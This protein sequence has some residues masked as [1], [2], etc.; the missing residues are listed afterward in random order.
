[1]PMIMNPFFFISE[2]CLKDV[3]M[4]RNKH[5]NTPPLQWDPVLAARAQA[6]AEK[7]KALALRTGSVQIIHDP[8]NWR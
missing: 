6:Y 1:M 5:I 2:G 4:Y 7:L 8:D 3:N